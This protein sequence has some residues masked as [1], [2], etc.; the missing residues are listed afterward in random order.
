MITIADALA[1]LRPG[2]TWIIYGNDYA[3]LQWLSPGSPPTI[4]EI[5]DKI[6]ELEA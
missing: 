4:E 6:A 1:A 5:M 2:T 3:T